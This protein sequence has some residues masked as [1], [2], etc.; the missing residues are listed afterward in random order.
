MPPRRDR[1]A[2]FRRPVRLCAMRR[3]ASCRSACSAGSRSRARSRQAATSAARRAGGRPDYPGDRRSR[4]DDPADRIAWHLGPADRTSC[5]PDHGGRRSRHRARLRPV[6]ASDTPDGS[7]RPARHRGLFRHGAA[8]LEAVPAEPEHADVL[9]DV[10]DSNCATARPSRCAVSIFTSAAANLSQS[11][12]ITAPAKP[13]CCAASRAWSG[14][15]PD[16]SLS[17]AKIPTASQ[18]ASQGCAA[19]SR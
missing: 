14:R 15:Q 10:A 2:R 1:P 16:R 8:T 4:G 5:R 19:A 12:A 13:R 17:V 11:S 7:G 9:L 18:R 6:I 3:R